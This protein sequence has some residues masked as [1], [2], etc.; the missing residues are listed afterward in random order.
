MASTSQSVRKRSVRRVKTLSVKKGRASICYD[1]VFPDF[2]S[3][4]ENSPNMIFV[5]YQGRVVYANRLCEHIM[6]YTKKEFYSA[7]FNFRNLIASESLPIIEKMFAGHIKGREQRPVEYKLITKKGE[8]LDV[9]I[10]A[11]LVDYHGDKAILGII[12]DVSSYRNVEFVLERERDLQKMYLD[13][14]DVILVALDTRLKVTAINKKGYELL[15]VD[16]CDIVG[17]DW[18]N[19]FIPKED[20]EKVR[21]SLEGFLEENVK[22]ESYEEGPILCRAGDCRFIRWSRRFLTGKHGEKIGLL[23][24]GLDITEQRQAED[25]LRESEKRYR[26]LFDNAPVGIYRTTPDGRILMANPA[27]VRMLGYRSFAELARVDLRH[28]KQGCHP[29]NPR[30]L[31]IEKIES[32]GRVIGLESKWT[33]ADGSVMHVRE[34]SRAIRNDSGR[35]LYYEGTVEDVTENKQTR[36]ELERR[37]QLERLITEIAA[38]FVNFSPGDVDAGISDLLKELG[39]FMGDDRSYIFQLSTDGNT[40][41]NTYEWVADGVK[42]EMENLKGLPLSGFPWLM[43]QLQAKQ[44]VKIPV[45][46]GLPYDASNEKKE[47]ISQNIRSLVLVPL[48]CGASVIGFFG[49]DSVKCEKDWD[50][51]TI[52]LLR[53]IGEIIASAL[54]RRRVEQELRYRLDFEKLITQISANFVNINPQ[55][56]DKVI[57]R[58]LGEIGLFCG[59]D[60]AFLFQLCG[61][62]EFMRTHWWD[63]SH[64]KPMPEDQQVIDASVVPGLFRPFLD[65]E[66]VCISRAEDLLKGGAGKG[67]DDLVDRMRKFG[68]ESMICVPLAIGGQT[69]AFVAFSSSQQGCSWSK[70]IILLMRVVGE[71]FAGAI[72][73]RGA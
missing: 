71:I 61:K 40:M 32:D 3:L 37:I 7:D 44:V 64:I 1:H 52:A 14:A 5:N 4:A 6:G 15:G 26:G 11:K 31:F 10:S 22:H 67:A 72:I 23:S 16:E 36:G 57:N 28:G 13:V 47:F 66:V 55:D 27:L 70:D 19:S 68:M 51:D 30:N 29:D 25:A 73:S 34:N 8:K 62:S 2:L 20:R 58:A 48:V 60:R 17:K 35:T 33:R 59:V 56:M 12:T 69:S 24:S 49:L 65:G 63:A 21:I 9:V 39:I 53:I 38:R 46:E 42:A 41:S 43:P 45:V 18:I 50:D 54:E